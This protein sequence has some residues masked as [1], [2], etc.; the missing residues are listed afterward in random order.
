[1]HFIKTVVS[2]FAF[3]SFAAARLDGSDSDLVR[4]E[5]AE[6]AHEEYLAARDEY[7]EKRELFRR[8]GGNGECRPAKGGTMYCYKGQKA[9]GTCAQTASKG[10]FCLCNK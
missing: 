10:Q 4:R 9:C 7:I 5:M 1:M 8:L 3:S 6:A 2:L